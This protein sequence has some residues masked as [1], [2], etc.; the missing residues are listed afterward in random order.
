MA[1]MHEGEE[2]KTRRDLGK[3]MDDSLT[4]ITTDLAADYSDLGIQHLLNDEI[5]KELSAFKHLLH[6]DLLTDLPYAKTA[7]GLFRIG[8]RIRARRFSK[9]LYAFL[10]QASAGLADEKTV[11]KYRTKVEHDPKFREDVVEHIITYIDALNSMTKSQILANLFVAFVEGHLTWRRF[12]DLSECLE[13]T[14]TLALDRLQMQDASTIPLE[15]LG[16]HRYAPIQA[17]T[18]AALLVAAGLAYEPQIPAEGGQTVLTPLGLELLV[19]GIRPD[20]PW[21]QV[22]V[23]QQ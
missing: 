21:K 20:A 4:E 18:E 5:L 22:L 1:Q 9:H 17:G 8:T 10:K 12:M 19:F 7:I 15:K 16:D 6:D 14:H 13:R 2:F 11:H 3:S 23:Q